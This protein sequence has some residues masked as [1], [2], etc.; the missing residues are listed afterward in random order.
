MKNASRTLSLVIACVI[1]V[2][3]CAWAQDWPQWRGANRDGKAGFAAPAEWPAALKQQWKATV[4]NG[5]STPALAGDRLYVFAKQDKDEVL[6]CL[7][8][9]DGKEIWRDTQKYEAPVISGPAASHPGPRS[10]PTVGEGKVVV[11]GAGGTLS[12][13]DAASGKLLWR[14]DEFPK[15]VPQFFTSMSPVIV[16]GMAIA[17]LGGKDNGAVMAFA[18]ATGDV[19]WK[20]AGEGPAYASPVVAAIGGVKQV[21]VLTE[22]SLV[23]LAVADGKLLWQAPTPLQKMAQN[24]PTPIVDG[25][26]IYISGQGSGTRAVK[27]V[28]EGDAFTTKD[29]W[30][31]PDLG[32]QFSTAVLKDGMLFAISNR[33]FLYCI[34]ARTGQTGW[35]DT[36]NLQNFGAIVDAGSA[37]VAL[38]SKSDM[39]V[40]KPDPK[41]FTKLAQYKVA[42]TPTYAHPILS[43]KRVFIK[44]AESL[45]LWTLD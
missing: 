27:V 12:C 43:G 21:V 7:N 15:V 22:K 42:D 39:V 34:D 16:D 32:G 6:M 4:G 8:A 45:T 40:F 18:L 28:K 24:A 20:W 35:A 41:A 31:N 23:G 33:G 44:D 19:K 29:A 26:T 2:G 25:D 14:K 30:T 38:P 1:L 11:L 3:V 37:I 13:F 5:D 10:S 36:T 9:A 17:H